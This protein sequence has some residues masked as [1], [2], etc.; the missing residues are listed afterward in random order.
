[1]TATAYL[2]SELKAIDEERYCAAGVLPYLT[3]LSDGTAGLWLLLARRSRQAS[4]GMLAGSARA[5]QL[6]MLGG[7]R[8][9]Y[10]QG[11]VQ[12]VRKECV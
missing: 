2:E 7:K 6:V 9:A 3:Q 8:E 1:M 4:S 11:A 12:T 10:D 5:G